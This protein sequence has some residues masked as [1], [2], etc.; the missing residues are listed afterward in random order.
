M[1]RWSRMVCRESVAAIWKEYPGIRV[2]DWLMFKAGTSGHESKALWRYN[3]CGLNVTL[4]NGGAGCNSKQTLP[5]TRYYRDILNWPVTDTDS[6]RIRLGCDSRV[7]YR[8]KSEKLCLSLSCLFPRAGTGSPFQP[9]LSSPTFPRALWTRILTLDYTETRQLG[10]AVPTR[11]GARHRGAHIGLPYLL[12]SHLTL[13]Y[14][15]VRGSGAYS[16]WERRLP[17]PPI[18][19]IRWCL[20]GAHRHGEHD[21]C[22]PRK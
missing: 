17:P 7:T 10:Q 3:C 19:R 13:I 12:V 4:H 22:W 11:H 16:W 14:F 9:S 15:G 18:S 5:T 8:N 2:V 1:W 6:N 21:T 20:L